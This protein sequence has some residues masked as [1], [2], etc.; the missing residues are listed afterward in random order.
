MYL[1]QGIQPNHILA[2]TDGTKAT[3]IDRILRE[4]V[5]I[6]WGDK[7]D[8][9]GRGYKAYSIRKWHLNKAKNRL[10]ENP[11]DLADRVGHRLDTLLEYYSDPSDVDYSNPNVTDDILNKTNKVKSIA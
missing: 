6:A 9:D 7:Y 3:N 8:N 4:A 1:E 11:A 2:K 10:K 5:R